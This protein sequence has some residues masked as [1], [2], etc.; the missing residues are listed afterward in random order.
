MA[1]CAGGFTLLELLFVLFVIG[2]MVG[3]IVPRFGPGLDRL[4]L[5]S[6]R[7]EIE[8]QLR[9]LPR[10]VRLT[11]RAIELP[12]DLALANL[13]DGV[14]PLGLPA[15][16][17]LEF[18]PPLVISRLGAC[19]ASHV[20]LISELQASASMRYQVAELTCELSDDATPNP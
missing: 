18:S 9:R 4:Q 17:Q 19:T 5:L 6:Q 20:H 3:L 1:G 13:G 14:P 10:R 15:G 11:G 12:A 8:D 2:L 16:W 7:Q